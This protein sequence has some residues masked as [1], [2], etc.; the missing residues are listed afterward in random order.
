M[1]NADLRFAKLVA[2]IYKELPPKPDDLDEP[3]R[4]L[5][6]IPNEQLGAILIQ[7]IG[8]TSDHKD[9]D[10]FHINGIVDLLDELKIPH[11]TFSY[12]GH[13]DLNYGP[14]DTKVEIAS[15]AKCL[16]HFV[17]AFPDGKVLIFA[18]SQG[19]SIAAHWVCRFSEPGDLDRIARV[20]FLACPLI[21]PVPPIAS[22]DDGARKQLV[23]LQ[24]VKGYSVEPSDLVTKLQHKYVVIRYW[25]D[26]LAPDKYSSFIDRD[27]S[28]SPL[29]ETT[30]STTSHM[31]IC[32]HRLTINIIRSHIEN[33]SLS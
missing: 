33:G 8:S 6:P 29:S 16:S 7:G 9:T 14:W 3:P 5:E 20:F 12:K 26:R 13:H 18:H 21:L 25:R 1:D 31:G 4:P 22:I 19:G 11:I 24:S 17:A 23:S 28:S 15:V 30:I 2:R 32:N 10:Y 27:R